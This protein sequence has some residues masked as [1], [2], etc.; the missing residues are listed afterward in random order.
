MSCNIHGF[1]EDIWYRI[2]SHRIASHRIA[3]HR[4]A[5]HIISYLI[6]SYHII[7]YHITSHQITSH[8][9]ISYRIVSY[10]ILSFR[11]VSYRI[12]S[13]RVL[14]DYFHLFGLVSIVAWV[15]NQI[16]RRVANE[17]TYPFPNF[18]GCPLKLDIWMNNFI[19]HFL[20][21]V[22]TYPCWD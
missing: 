4:I 1:V 18:N 12:V 2:V 7:S 19:P 20:V 21:D 3:S 5:Y 17:N 11:F 16:S 10:H 6:I 9:I 22:V 15:S 8:H 14:C 13:W